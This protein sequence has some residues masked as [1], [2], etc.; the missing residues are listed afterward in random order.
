MY[1]TKLWGNILN[2]SEFNNTQIYKIIRNNYI[3]DITQDNNS[4]FIRIFDN[5]NQLLLEFIEKFI[6]NIYFIRTIKDYEYHFKNDKLVTQ[7]S[8]KKNI[9]FIDKIKQDTVINNNIITLDLEKISNNINNE[10]VLTVIS[11][12]IFDGDN[13]LS[14]ELQS[15]K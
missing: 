6:N 9:K 1:N 14:L 3:I 4:R 5:N 10:E 13:K 12:Y 8:D 15:D 11:A 7:V 2:K